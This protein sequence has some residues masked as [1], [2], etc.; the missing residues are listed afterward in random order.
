MIHQ[1]VERL[2]ASGTEVML[3]NPQ[4]APK[5]IAKADVAHVVDV[6]TATARDEQVGLFDRFTTMRYWYESEKLPF[7]QFLAADGVHM[8]D[9]SYACVAKLLASAIADGAKPP[10]ATATMTPDL[11]KR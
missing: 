9:W 11:I 2:K 5:I 7:E 3:I 6:I 8:N 1:G 10:A 4:Y